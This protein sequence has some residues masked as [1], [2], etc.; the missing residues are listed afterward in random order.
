MAVIK[1][2]GFSGEQ[3][4]IIPRLIPGN[5]AQSAVNTRLDD[6]ALTP[7]RRAASIVPAGSADW[8]TIYRHQ[9][10]WLGWPAIVNAVPGPVADDRL[11]YTGDGVPKVRIGGTVYPLAVPRP[12]PQLSGASSGPGTGTLVTRLYVHTWVTSYGEESEPGPT[13]TPVEWRAGQQVTLQGFGAA[14]LGRAITHQRIYRSQTGQQGT[15]FYLIA[16]RLVTTADFV[17]DIEPSA[18]QEPLPSSNWNAPPDDLTGLAGL[19]NGMMAAFVG[20]QLYFCEPWR[21]HAWPER[22]V[23]T[24]ETP[25]VGLGA[26]GDVLIVTT[27]GYPYIVT[28]ATPETMQMQKVEQNLACINARGIVDLGYSIAW[29]SHDGLV[30]AKADGS[31]GYV[32]A[33]IF[34]RDEWLALSPRTMIGAQHMGRYIAFYDTF[35]GIGEP[36]A[37]ALIIAVQEATFLV[38]AAERASAAWYDIGNGGLYYLTGDPAEIRRFDAPNA[39]RSRQYWLSKPFVMPYPD[40]YGAI[41]VELGPDEIIEHPEGIAAAEVALAAAVAAVIEANEALIAAGTIEGETDGAAMDLYALD[42]DELAL[43]PG[44]VE[45]VVEVGIFA[46]GEKV[47]TVTRMNTPARLPSGF[48]AR[49]W[50]IDVTGDLRVDRIVMAKTM[51]ELRQVAD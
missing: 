30:V 2:I 49:T 35:D 12:T 48:R 36:T 11:Y 19:P 47:A 29:P 34:N 22:F 3:P 50:E 1:L 4:R 13:S 33:N 39:S 27:E 17:D 10:E 51:D 44:P 20:R 15:F 18:F 37:G 14:P 7:M 5:A 46:D 38:R 45:G 21:P 43:P 31:V 41:R 28:G 32:T 40:N 9:G 16:E 6:G 8:K 42:G 26:V 25:I 23:L 24:T